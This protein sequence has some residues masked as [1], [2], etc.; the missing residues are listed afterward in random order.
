MEVELAINLVGLAISVFIGRY[1]YV[2][3][4]AVGSPNLLR[5][6]LAFVSIATGFVLLIGAIFLSDYVQAM[7]TVGLAAQAVGYFFIA[8]SHGLKSSFDY[9]PRQSALMLVPLATAPFVIPGNSIEH[10]VRS[11]SFILLVY[12]SIETIASYMQTMRSNTL[13]IGTGLG[14]LAV[15]ELI[16]WYNFIFPGVF[17]Y[18]AIATKVAGF[19]LMLVPFSKIGLGRIEKVD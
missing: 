16:A 13:M 5:L 14:T 6:T 10:L 4:A 17:E 9:A 18:P 19:G 2:G 12:V 15:A 11:I 7:N 1:A 8:L 3:Y